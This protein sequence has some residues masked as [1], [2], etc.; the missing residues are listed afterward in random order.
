MAVIKKFR[1]KS[2]KAEESLVELKNQFLDL[3]PGWQEPQIGCRGL[4][5]PS[6]FGYS[7]PFY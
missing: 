4:E 2:F 5:L 7:S 1:I 6:L 3:F